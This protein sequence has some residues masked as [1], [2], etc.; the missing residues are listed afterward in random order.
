MRLHLHNN[1]INMS[2]NF[3][4]LDN[5][6]EAIN[7]WLISE[8]SS[9]R[10]GKASPAILDIIKIDSYGSKVP[11]NQIASVSIE[12]AKTLLVT[13]W[14][15]NLAKP[16]ES[17]ILTSDLGLSV[18]GGD[19]SIRVGFPELTSERRTQLIKITKSKLEEAKISIRK[20]REREISLIKKLPSEND[21]KIYIQEVEVKVKKAN[22]NLTVLTNDKEKSLSL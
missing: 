4:T 3:S 17:A 21:Q 1:L 19:T 2:H 22:D 12:D 7:K 10:T 9:I 14:D 6:I 18:L 15:K 8:F 5:R 11:L 13:P 16:I 20:E